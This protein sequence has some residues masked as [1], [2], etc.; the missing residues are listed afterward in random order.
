MLSGSYVFY[1][2]HPWYVWCEEWLFLPYVLFSG[3]Q[4]E[5]HLY[6]HVPFMS[7]AKWLTFVDV[8]VL[9]AITV[10]YW[11]IFSFGV[12]L[13]ALEIG[14]CCWLFVELSTVFNMSGK[15][16]SMVGNN[17]SY[18][19]CKGSIWIL[20]LLLM[21][22]A[23]FLSSFMWFLH[24]CQMLAGYMK[25]MLPTQ[26]CSTILTLPKYSASTSCL[27]AWYVKCE[28]SLVC[29]GATCI[30]LLQLLWPKINWITRHIRFISTLAY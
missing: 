16:F 24:T 18:L 25:L 20:Y 10:L 7:V 9:W 1:F 11:F 8:L 19:N 30:K 14:W 12:L 27:Q 28:E 29:A 17:L 26:L 15:S 3:I 4:C 21:Y 13:F 6:P 23:L 22:V 5:M 2:F